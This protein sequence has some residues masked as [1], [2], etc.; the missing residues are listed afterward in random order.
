M[1]SN[2]IEHALPNYTH[3]NRIFDSVSEQQA[4]TNCSHLAQGSTAPTQSKPL[5]ALIVLNNTLDSLFPLL[6]NLSTIHIFADGGCNRVYDT[7]AGER[8]RYLP[9]VIVGDL[10]SVRD[11]VIEYYKTE[12]HIPVLQDQDNYAT[13]FHKSLHY[14][15]TTYTIQQCHTMIV[16]VHNGIGGR[17][18]QQM[19]CI[20]TLYRYEQYFQRLLLVSL[21][22]LVE[23]L[24]AGYHTINLS[25]LYEPSTITH[26]GLFTLHGS[27]KNVSTKGLE[28]NLEHQTVGWKDNEMMSYCNLI[29]DD[30]REVVIECEDAVVWTTELGGKK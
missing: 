13:D 30:A 7:Y 10:D 18:D 17:F 22:N 19:G 11:E 16:L 26:C 5:I 21:G 15:T 24:R 20:H 14:L 25:Q 12:H 23:V 6:Y 3:N 2:T 4:P 9:D 1:S 8:S 27:V 29:A 28:W